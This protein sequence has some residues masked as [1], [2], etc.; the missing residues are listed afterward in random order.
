MSIVRP[1]LLRIGQLARKAGVNVQTI[2]FYEREGLLAP[3]S[4]TPSGYRAYA[5][6]DLE[7]VRVIRTCQRIGFTLKDVKV[8][9]EP[10]RVLASRAAA[11]GAKS[12]AR[13]KML[14]SA[15][16]R[17]ALLDEALAALT[18]MRADMASLVATLA[19]GDIMV[20]PASRAQ[21]RL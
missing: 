8:V 6:S 15:R 14:A 4:R 12:A 2:R 9:L 3:P 10:H 16:Q 21:A 7:R 11:S 1:Q 5:A 19:D 20:C 18:R 13:D 17:L